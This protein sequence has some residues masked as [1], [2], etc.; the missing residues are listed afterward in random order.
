MY[1]TQQLLAGIASK[2]SEI[3]I[4]MFSESFLNCKIALTII[5]LHLKIMVRS[6]YRDYYL[7]YWNFSEIV[8]LKKV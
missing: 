1:E 2:N 3:F 5:S 7:I 8:D 4:S 6:V